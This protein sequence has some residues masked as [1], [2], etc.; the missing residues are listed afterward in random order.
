[1]TR[2]SIAVVVRRRRA[3]RCA[4]ARAARSSSPPARIAGA[5]SGDDA[6]CCRQN[7]DGDRSLQPRVT[8]PV[9]L[10]HP[11]RAERR[12]DL[13]GTEARA[14]SDA[15]LLFLLVRPV[16][17]NGDRQ[18]VSPKELTRKRCPSAVTS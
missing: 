17:N 18:R 9:D 2:Y 15:H 14:L 11:A 3:R 7:L 13:V 6:E 10:A 5:T 1:M 16:Q 12:E 8:R 4:D